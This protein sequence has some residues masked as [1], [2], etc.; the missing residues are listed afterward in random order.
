MRDTGIQKAIYNT[1]FQLMAVKQ[2]HP[3]YLEQ[4]EDAPPCTG[5]LP[6]SSNR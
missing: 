5:S 1:I 3:E 4:A 6:L 2:K